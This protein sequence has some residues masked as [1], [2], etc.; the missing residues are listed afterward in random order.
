MKS[1]QNWGVFL[2][3]AGVLLIPVGAVRADLTDDVLKTFAFRSIGPA[4]MGGRIDD[5]AVDPQNPEMFYVATASGGL[6]K[7]TSG[8]VTYTPVFDNEATSSIGDVT[9]APSNSD[10]VWVGTGEA[11]NRQSSSW[12][13]GVYRSTDAGKTWTHCGLANTHHIARIVV[14]PTNPDIAY[15]A[16]L[17]R[18][19][20]A[21]EDRGVYKTTDGGKTWAKVLYISP[22][23]GVTDIVLDPKSPETLYAASYTRRRTPF[24]F[25]GE[26]QNDETGIHKSTDGGNNWERVDTGL[27][28]GKL[29]RIGLAIS[30]KNPQVLMATVETV[31]P[32][33]VNGNG[34][35][36]YRTENGGKN[37]EKRAEVNPRP[38]YFSQIIIDPSDDQN[39][40]VLG[41]TTWYYS[42]NGGTSF[43]T[44][45]SR[46]HADGHAFW[47]DPRNPKHLLLGCDGGIYQSA[48]QGITFDHQS[49]IPL[50]QFYE[51]AFDYQKPYYVYGGLQD[52]GSWGAPNLSTDFR[53]INNFDW[54]SLNGGDGFH[55]QADP[56]NPN[57]VYVESQNG[58]VQRV[59]PKTGDSRSARPR[60]TTP[61]E[62]LRFDWNTPF[63]I[64]PHNPKRFYVAAN[65]LY[66]SESRGEEYYWRETPDLTNSIDR[67]KLAILGKPA[68]K[69]TLSAFDGEDSFSEIVTISESPKQKGILYVG[70]DDGN[71]QV[72]LDDGRNFRN[73]ISNVTGVPY[74]TYVSRVVASSHVAGRVYATFD[75]HRNN[76]FLPYVYV[77]EDFGETWRNIT[78]NLPEFSTVSVIREHPRNQNL[79]FVGTERGL[80][81]STDRGENWK[82]FKN[83][84]PMVPVDDIQIHPRENDLILA[85]HGRGIWICDDI[86]ALEKTSEAALSPTY[87][88]PPRPVV[89]YRQT[90]LSGASGHKHYFG[91]NPSVGA[92]FD[93]YLGTLPPVKTIKIKD[94]NGK[95][96]E[97][98][99][100][101]ILKLEVL[102][103]KKIVRAISIESAKAGWN[104]AFWNGR[105]D[106]VPGVSPRVLP[107]KYTIRLTVEKTTF[108]QS[109]TIEEDPKITASLGELKTRNAFLEEN[110]KTYKQALEISKTLT[111]IRTSLGKL[112]A[113]DAY[114]KLDAK[115]NTKVQ[116]EAFQK[117]LESLTS[118]V[119]TGG[120]NRPPALMTRVVRLENAVE[121]FPEAPSKAYQSEANFLRGQLSAAQNKLGELQKMRGSLNGLLKAQKM[122]EVTDVA[123]PVVPAPTTPA[124]PPQ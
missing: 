108:S 89:L 58:G 13:N 75:G 87:L 38:M 106:V 84:L 48:D 8:G 61:G 91:T 12:G 41:A 29:G 23:T 55:A 70:T 103:G 32:P 45:F 37:W 57:I 98:K 6:F 14:H 36:V 11:N 105:Y 107:G 9:L 60:P 119:A 4:V 72:S 44:V 74:G 59:T 62:A 22:D 40:Y 43:N 116:V 33:G 109:F 25:S 28:E 123:P 118:T 73:I 1:G 54:L 83:N 5:F 47:I 63:L 112:T 115:D 117:Q 34:G 96:T 104:R 17:G 2:G 66:I 120:V 97:Q 7:T 88:A 78:H 39:V 20:G 82:I 85:T 95:E 86:T 94:K 65:R 100:D 76:D 114:K 15:V 30:V 93:Y 121:S 101:P 122:Q 26:G 81:V 35:S 92:R 79:L 24:G 80:Y 67:D 42:T 77:S 51:V 46:V 50:A 124:P 69:D 64:S 68:T 49:L 18:L 10:V 21:S 31:N 19:W 53:G 113:T 102:E 52:N 110:A 16:A 71:L 99:I 111:N 27:P 90:G 56:T 3:L